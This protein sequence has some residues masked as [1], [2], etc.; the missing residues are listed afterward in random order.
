MGPAARLRGRARLLTLA[1]VSLLVAVGGCDGAS[2]DVRL[3]VSPAA[4]RM[5]EPVEL[6]VTGLAPGSATEV[7]VRS[8]DAGG[9]VWTSSATFAADAS[10]RVDPSTM[11][12]TS[13]GYAGAWAMG[14]FGLMTTSAP[15]PSYRWPTTGPATFD[16]EAVQNGRTVASTSV[17]RTF[18]TAPPKITS[19][20]RA[21]DGF[22]GTSVVPA[23][24][25]R[26]PAALLLG[27]SEGGDPAIGAYLLAARG[28]PTLSVAYFEAPGLPSA[29]RNI[30]LEYFDTPLR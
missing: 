1:L 27:G 12:P 14:L 30:P 20:T 3:V 19:F 18:W 29:L 7:S 2:S 16:V 8:V 6:V 15:G 26:G 23:G 17:A 5:D 22:V 28:I 4:T 9:T 25:Q 24:A 10:G 11:A 21:A 13:G